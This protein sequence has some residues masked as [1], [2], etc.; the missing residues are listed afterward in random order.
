MAA[1]EPL[2]GPGE[3][4][5]ARHPGLEGGVDLPGQDAA[6]LLLA[7][8]ERIDA[9]FGQHQRLVDGDIV[10]PGD[11]PAEGGLIVQID[12]EADEIG[13]I[14]GQVFGGRVVG[15]AD[16]R[17]G[18]LGLDAGDEALEKAAHRARRHASEPY[19]AGSH[20]R[21]DRRRPPGD[22]GSARTPAITASRICC[23]VAGLSRNATCCDHG[24]PTSSFKP[25]LLG[26]VEQPQRRDGKDPDGVDAGFG[27][28]REIGIDHRAFG[29]LRAMAAL[30]ERAVGDPFD[31]VLALPDKEELALHA[32]RTG[33]VELCR[34]AGGGR[35]AT[36]SVSTI[37]ISEA[38]GMPAA[39]A[40]PRAWAALA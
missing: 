39:A 38:P 31:E 32:H 30:R 22:G 37:V 33:R 27:H 16:E 3:D 28:Q 15:V 34:R 1:G 5:G 40:N 4:K 26:R 11:V 14:D 24:S 23:W 35:V 36:S 17:V 10:Q 6:L 19:R 18:V 25:G 9:E 12:V 2:V 21:S 29:K 7:L 8:A 20:C 13:E